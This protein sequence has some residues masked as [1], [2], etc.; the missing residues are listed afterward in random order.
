MTQ[1]GDVHLLI[2]A[3]VDGELDAATALEIERRIATDPSL[4]RHYASMVAVKKAVEDLPR[5]E[6]SDEFSA[7]IAA[8]A[9]PPLSAKPSPVAWHLPPHDWRALAASIVVTALVASGATYFVA[10]PSP[11][12]GLA[13]AIAGDHRRSLLAASPVD[14]ASSDRHTVKPWLDARVGLSPPAV[15]MA[16]KGFMLVGGR[17]E[18]MDDRAVPALVYRHNQHLVTLV[19]LPMANARSQ[20][21]EH[22][23]AGGFGMI[24]WAGEGF[25][26][27]AISDMERAELEVFVAEFRRRVAQQ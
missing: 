14:I 17:V 23:A 3:L 22:L 1:P 24:R 4:A 9:A 5:P 25:S 15:D 10:A 16:D 21:P 13:S 27:W 11:D 12:T 19:A 2:Q 26:Y 7:R 20:A 8:M 6:I 18:V